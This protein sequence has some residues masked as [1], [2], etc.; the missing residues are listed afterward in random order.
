VAVHVPL[1]RPLRRLRVTV[2]RQLSEHGHRNERRRTGQE[3]AS[4]KFSHD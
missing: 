3:P 2:E 1:E 4:S